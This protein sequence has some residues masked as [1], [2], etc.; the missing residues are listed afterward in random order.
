[1][2]NVCL[3]TWFGLILFAN[4]AWSSTV[5]PPFTGTIMVIC[6]SPT[7]ATSCTDIGGGATGSIDTTVQAGTGTVSGQGTASAEYGMLHT[8]ISST[9]TGSTS[10][11]YVGAGANATFIDDF[12]VNFAP[13]TGDAGFMALVVTVDGT[14]TSSGSMISYA[15]VTYEVN[16]GQGFGIPTTLYLPDDAVSGQFTLGYIPFTYGDTFA[17]DLGFSATVQSGSLQNGIPSFS[18]T[19]QS[20]SGTS[21]FDDTL[22]VSG[23]TIFD[24]NMDLVPGATISSGSGTVYTQDG[25]VP[26]PS[27]VVLVGILTVVTLFLRCSSNLPNTWEK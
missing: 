21:D 7:A 24:S 23:L 17:L 8:D 26:E 5:T 19:T 27:Y 20:G 13:F 25:V 22:T 4:C 11:L 15:S 1:M 14:N 3:V 18:P 2:R 9:Y 16:Y 12:T 6:A 10:S